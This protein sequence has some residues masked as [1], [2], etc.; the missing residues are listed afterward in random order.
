MYKFIALSRKLPRVEKLGRVGVTPP[1]SVHLV[2]VTHNVKG[3]KQ[4]DAPD[5]R[6]E[7]LSYRRICGMAF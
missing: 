6:E 7:L 1:K 2:P 3:E 5:R 4:D